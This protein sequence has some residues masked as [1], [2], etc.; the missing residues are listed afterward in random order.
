M[1]ICGVHDLKLRKDANNYWIPGISKDV[2]LY[3][4]QTNES[5]DLL[6]KNRYS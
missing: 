4:S 1:P 5:Y 3:N 2:K 6:V